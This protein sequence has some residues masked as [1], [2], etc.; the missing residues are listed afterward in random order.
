MREGNWADSKRLQGGLWLHFFLYLVLVGHISCLIFVQG[1][2]CVML[3]KTDQ[4]QDWRR[5]LRFCSPSLALSNNTKSLTAFSLLPGLSFVIRQWT[6]AAVVSISR[7]CDAKIIVCGMRFW[8]TPFVLLIVYYFLI[9]F[10]MCCKTLLL[11]FLSVYLCIWSEI[12]RFW[13]FINISFVFLQKLFVIIAFSKHIVEQMVSL[14][15]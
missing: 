12:N 14:I 13:A 7:S 15:G 10:S 9:F 8:E 2:M 6:V 3:F 4:F 1:T 11:V 5:T